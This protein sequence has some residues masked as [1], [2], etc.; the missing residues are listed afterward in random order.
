M[1]HQQFIHMIKCISTKLNV[2]Y[3]E[4]LE[5]IATCENEMKAEL[6]MNNLRRAAILRERLYQRMVDTGMEIPWDA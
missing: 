5:R 3:L 6:K 2:P 4:I 1:N